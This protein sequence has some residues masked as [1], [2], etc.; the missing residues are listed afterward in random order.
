MIVYNW[1][2][3]YDLSYLSAP[4][5]FLDTYDVNGRPRRRRFRR[6]QPVGSEL[7]NLVVILV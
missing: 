3:E 1:F 2:A 7:E 4:Y 6:N 5:I